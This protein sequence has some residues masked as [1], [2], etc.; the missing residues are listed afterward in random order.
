MRTDPG[1]CPRFDRFIAAEA[2]NRMSSAGDAQLDM[3]AYIEQCNLAGLPLSGRYLINIVCRQFDVDRQRGAVLTKVSLYAIQLEDFS[4]DG[5]RDFKNRVQY[6]LS[7]IRESEHPD[8]FESG[9]WL[10]QKLKTCRRLE[11]HIEAIK[12]S[13]VKS[14]KRR[15]EWLWGKLKKL[16]TDSREDVNATS[17]NDSLTQGTKSR[18]KKK[19]KPGAPGTGGGGSTQQQIDAL[20]KQLDAATAGADAAAGAA[21][22]KGKGKGKK[23]KGKDDSSAVPKKS[24]AE[25]PPKREPK[26]IA[27]MFEVKQKDSCSQGAKCAFAHDEAIVAPAREKAAA[28]AKNK[29]KGNNKAKPGG[30]GLAV[31]AVVG[32][33]CIQPTTECDPEETVLHSD[34]PGSDGVGTLASALMLPEQDSQLWSKSYDSS[35]LLLQ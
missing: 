23:G 17:V 31:Q 21:G 2:A 29:G 32:S 14:K 28:K 13:K 5:L 16:L 3:Q 35:N 9:E 19:A 10:L 26:T 15:F 1:L 25:P 20:Q 22:T 33:T 6:A 11:T 4:I 8:P 34:A 18:A 27:C 30:V 7:S 12:E 24:G